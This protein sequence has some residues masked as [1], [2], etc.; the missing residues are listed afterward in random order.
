M[1]LEIRVAKVIDTETIVINKGRKDKI[2]NNM[3]FIV[4]EE[5]GEIMD[6]LT[7]ESLGKLEKVKGIFRTSH[8][9]DNITTLISKIHR[10][11]PLFDIPPVLGEVNSE[12][13]A[14]K[15]IKTGDKVKITNRI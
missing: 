4:Y 12:L 8:V 3:E 11:N 1:E 14:L 2:D 9:Q 15:T 5:G 13:E 7:G 10:K 6:P